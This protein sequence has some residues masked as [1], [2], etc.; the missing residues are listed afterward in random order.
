M[1][2]DALKICKHFPLPSHRFLLVFL[3]VLFSRFLGGDGGCLK[4]LLARESSGG[5]ESPTC[6]LLMNLQKIKGPKGMKVSLA[7]ARMTLICWGLSAEWLKG[8][9]CHCLT[10]ILGQGMCWCMGQTMP[11]SLV[12]T[13]ETHTWDSRHLPAP[14]QIPGLDHVWPVVT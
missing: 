3:Y 10:P 12:E 8:S 9:G 6:P 1:T 2:Q 13:P 11:G 4:W 5:W 14:C 7:G